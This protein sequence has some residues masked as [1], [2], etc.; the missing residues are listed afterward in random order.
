MIKTIGKYS[1]YTDKCLGQGSFGKVF[2]GFENDTKEKVAIKKVDF[3][4]LE[5]DR[6]L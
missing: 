3:K 5:K 6:Y 2:Q 4:T 1:Y